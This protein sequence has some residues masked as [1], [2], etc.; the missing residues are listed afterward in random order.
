MEMDFRTLIFVLTAILVFS[1]LLGPAHKAQVDPVC[2]GRV[3][4]D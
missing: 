2:W 1:W 4:D 3:C